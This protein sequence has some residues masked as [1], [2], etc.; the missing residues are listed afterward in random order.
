MT[1]TQGGSRASS[2]FTQ[3]QQCSIASAFSH[4]RQQQST[5]TASRAQ[6]GSMVKAAHHSQA[7]SNSTQ[8]K[9]STKS[10]PTAHS[11]R[12]NKEAGQH[13]DSQD[14]R[15]AR[16]RVTAHHTTNQA[17]QH[18]QSHIRILITSH[19]Q[20]TSSSSRSTRVHHSVRA[21][22]HTTASIIGRA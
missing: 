17:K 3:Q 13:P 18:T 5:P 6:H 14:T 2:R 19:T 8:T 16:H 20:H 9:E 4:I 21:H 11:N 22:Q 1:D 10:A 12:S 15:C 7:R